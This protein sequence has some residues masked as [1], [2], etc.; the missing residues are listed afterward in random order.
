MLI[1]NLIVYYMV[2]GDS[3]TV[4]QI[5]HSRSNQA[6]RLNEDAESP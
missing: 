3:V 6:S 4:H 5:L 2:D 1:G